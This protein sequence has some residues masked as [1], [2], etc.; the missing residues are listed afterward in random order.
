MENIKNPENKSENAENPENEFINIKDLSEEEQK[1]KSIVDNK[2]RKNAEN[3][4]PP[5][6]WKNQQQAY[7]DAWE[8]NK[9]QAL[10]DDI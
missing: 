4:V 6:A 2:N 3:T 9:N 1:L 7:K 8:N 5:D 10:E